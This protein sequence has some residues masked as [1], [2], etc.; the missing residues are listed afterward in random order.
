MLL[1]IFWVCLLSLLPALVSGQGQFT[2]PDG[3]SND[4]SQSYVVGS[5][6]VLTWKGGWSGI[7]TKQDFVDLFLTSFDDGTYLSLLASKTPLLS[8]HRLWLI[9]ICREHIAGA[10]WIVQVDH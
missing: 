10:G 2:N 1:S 9:V 3:N 6:A 7:G 8:T 4:L 5:T